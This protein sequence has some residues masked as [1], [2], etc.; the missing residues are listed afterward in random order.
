[1]IIGQ[2]IEIT[3]RKKM[4]IA[5]RNTFDCSAAIELAKEASDRGGRCPTSDT[6]VPLGYI[7]PEMWQF[8]P[9]LVEANKARCY[10]DMITY[11]VNIMKFF[12]LFPQ[13]SVLQS[14]KYY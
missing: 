10:G 8:N 12:K 5:V 7:P 9:W 4:E 6:V 11:Q 13:F 1:M 2:N 14:R 3:D